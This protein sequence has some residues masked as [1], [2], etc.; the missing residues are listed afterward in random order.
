MVKQANV[1]KKDIRRAKD[2]F[3]MAVAFRDA[4]SAFLM[5]MLYAGDVPLHVLNMRTMQEEVQAKNGD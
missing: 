2:A 4:N 5:R 3:S 1:T